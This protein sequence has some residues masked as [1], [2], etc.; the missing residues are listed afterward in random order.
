M[1]A[2]SRGRCPYCR[3]HGWSFWP[4]RCPCGRCASHLDLRLAYPAAK[5]AA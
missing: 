3:Y 2:W 4:G 5:E 1:S